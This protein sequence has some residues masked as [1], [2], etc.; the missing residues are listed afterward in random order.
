MLQLKKYDVYLGLV[1]LIRKTTKIGTKLSVLG[2]EGEGI[3]EK[4]ESIAELKTEDFISK[5]VTIMRLRR[6]AL[7]G[8]LDNV[9]I[10]EAI[11]ES[12]KVMDILN[13]HQKLKH[14][15][16]EIEKKLT[17]VNKFYKNS[18]LKLIPSM[19]WVD[20]NDIEYLQDRV[21][22]EEER[23]K[24]LDAYIQEFWIKKVLK[25]V[26]IALLV[27]LVIIYIWLNGQT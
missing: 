19:E 16:S 24:E 15:K 21:K 2:G 17:K 22:T 7:H 11:K 6:N 9:Q 27:L 5:I 14:L 10:N 25:P 23:L 8:D 20:S 4:S 12:D 1:S 13:I 18:S 26:G 3:L